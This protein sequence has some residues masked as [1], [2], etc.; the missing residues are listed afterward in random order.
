MIERVD[1]V[2]NPP[3][4]HVTLLHTHTFN[5]IRLIIFLNSVVYMTMQI[6]GYFN[7][8]LGPGAY[9]DFFL[10]VDGSVSIHYPFEL[11]NTY[12]LDTWQWLRDEEPGRSC[13]PKEGFA[14]ITYTTHTPPGRGHDGNWTAR[15]DF[16]T[17]DKRNIFCPEGW[18][19]WPPANVTE[20]I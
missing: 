16:L 13:P 17:K 3:I 20:P 6:W 19:L 10:T 15:A 12:H 8:D 14:E 4:P 11:C 7:E 1:L 5:F 18:V 9:V 2:P